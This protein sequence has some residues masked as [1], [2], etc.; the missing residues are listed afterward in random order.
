MLKNQLSY[1]SILAVLIGLLLFSSEEYLFYVIILM[2]VLAAVSALLTKLDAAGMRIMHTIKPGTQEK[3][4]LELSVKVDARRMTAAR[5]VMVEFEVKNNMFDTYEKRRLLLELSDGK[6]IFNV[7]F[8][9]EYCGEMTFRC[10]SARVYDIF[11]LLSVPVISD[12]AAYC[13]VYPRKFNIKIN[14]RKTAIGSSRESM[15]VQ[16]RKGHDLSEMF[17]LKNYKE[18][19][20]VRSIN[21]KLSSKTVDGSLISRQPS[22]PTRYDIVLM[23]DIGFRSSDKSIQYD[24]LNTAIALCAALS[25]QLVKNKISFCLMIPRENGLEV[26]E[27]H[28]NNDLQHAMRQWLQLKIPDTSGIGMKYFIMEKL[29]YNCTKLIVISAGHIIQNF[30]G[31]DDTIGV[32]AINTTSKTDKLVTGIDGNCETLEFPSNADKESVYRIIC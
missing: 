22:D 19:D 21:W 9:A 12:N 10:A 1:I 4:N 28:D 6:N 14:M 11:G 32:M 26:N 18:G 5:T 17:D 30:R 31:I 27:I 24:D 13:I 29:Y 15:M 20:D 7:P 8:N 2:T 16:N 3:H 23:P 25:E